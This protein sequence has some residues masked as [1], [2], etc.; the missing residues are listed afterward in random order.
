MGTVR[1][2]RTVRRYLPFYSSTRDS[3]LTLLDCIEPEVEPLGHEQLP[4]EFSGDIREDFWSHVG[5]AWEFYT[6]W[7][8]I[9]AD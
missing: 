8:C 2:V 4:D 5:T 7:D 3:G 6:S 1:T 9:A